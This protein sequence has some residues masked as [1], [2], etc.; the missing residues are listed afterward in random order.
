MADARSV[1]GFVD[2]VACHSEATSGFPTTM[3]VAASSPLSGVR[4]VH[5]GRTRSPSVQFIPDRFN[6]DIELS[7]PSR[8]QAM[9]ADPHQRL[10]EQSSSQH[11]AKSG[12]VLSVLGYFE[13]SGVSWLHLGGSGSEASHAPVLLY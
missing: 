12:A 8:T 5:C 6:G 2:P 4:K 3:S 1:A 7:D 13:I 9:N 11:L 10:E